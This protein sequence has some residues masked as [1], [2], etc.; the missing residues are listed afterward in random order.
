LKKNGIPVW[1]RFFN[2][3]RSSRSIEVRRLPNGRFLEAKWI[4]HS[5]DVADSHYDAVIDTDFDAVTN[6]PKEIPRKAD[7]PRQDDDLRQDDAEAA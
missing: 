7:D 3:L 2:S 4:G 6:P 5:V 1:Q